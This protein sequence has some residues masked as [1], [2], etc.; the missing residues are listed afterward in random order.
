[1]SA[2]GG[3]ASVQPIS[4]SISSGHVSTSI[5]SPPVAASSSPSFSFNGASY[6]PTKSIATS[7]VAGSDG[8]FTPSTMQLQFVGQ[9]Q[10]QQQQQ[11]RSGLVAHHADVTSVNGSSSSPNAS[12]MRVATG[13]SPV[14]AKRVQLR[15][16]AQ[17][18]VPSFVSSGGSK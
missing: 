5:S 17:E 18:F 7:K 1:M 14:S 8:S 12:I 10:Q 15:A 13:D 4:S 9:G 3:G 6:N 2:G 16:E 11:Q